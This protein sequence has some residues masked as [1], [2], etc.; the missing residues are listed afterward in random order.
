MDFFEY[1]GWVK[2]RRDANQKNIV[3]MSGMSRMRRGHDENPLGKHKT[4]ADLHH[5]LSLI[6]HLLDNTLSDTYI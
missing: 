5:I 4:G 3:G 6:C 1:R 2:R